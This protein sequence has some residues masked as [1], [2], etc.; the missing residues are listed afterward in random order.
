MKRSTLLT[1]AFATLFSFTAF[2]SDPIGKPTSVKILPTK[3]G[4]VKVLYVN[5]QEKKVDVKIFGQEGLVIKDRVKLS[6]SDNGF[7]RSYNLKELEPGT[8]WVEIS[9]SNTVVKY[10]ITY[11]NN[12]IV[13]AKYWNSMMPSNEA[14]A[15]N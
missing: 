8:Y 12:Q 5:D 7:L 9:D 10:E 4:M 14:L 6:K 2:A 15:S 1:L 11:Q 3:A 13:W